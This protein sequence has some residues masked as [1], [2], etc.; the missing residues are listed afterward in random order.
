MFSPRA[1]LFYLLLIAIPLATAKIFT[2]CELAEKLRALKAPPE[3][4]PTWVCIAEHESRLDTSAVGPPNGDGSRDHGLLQI[5]DRYWCWVQEDGP[6]A[7]GNKCSDFEDD[8]IRDDFIC[9]RRVFR[10]TKRRTGNGFTA[11]VVYGQHC[12]GPD[13]GRYTSECSA[14]AKNET[15]R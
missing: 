6:A 14:V 1:N 13:V 3:D 10:A 7:C 5:N 9:A 11:W 4:I 12:N 8:D 15:T 2:K